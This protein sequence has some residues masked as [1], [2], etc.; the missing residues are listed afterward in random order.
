MQSNVS[1]IKRMLVAGNTNVIISSLHILISIISLIFSANSIW[2]SILFF[3]L[4]SKPTSSNQKSIPSCSRF[5][6]KVIRLILVVFKQEKIS[7]SGLRFVL[8][9]SSCL[10]SVVFVVFIFC[11][12]KLAAVS[13][14]W[15]VVISLGIVSTLAAVD[16][17]SI[18]WVCS[19]LLLSRGLFSSVSFSLISF[20]IRSFSICSF[21]IRSSSILSIFSFSILSFSIFSFSVL[22]FSTSTHYVK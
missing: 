17:V 11:L 14:T 2:I 13:I 5:L 9:I 16:D 4:E 21:S 22:S 1:G 12:D 15:V 3:N 8:C 7:N 20:S 6:K 18:T 19:V 10:I